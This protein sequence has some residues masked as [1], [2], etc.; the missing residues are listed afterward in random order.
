MI[1]ERRNKMMSRGLVTTFVL[2]AALLAVAGQRAALVGA[3]APLTPVSNLSDKDATSDELREE[4]HQS[5][6]LTANGRVSIENLNGGVRVAVW[7]QNEVKVD[8]VKRAFK[9]E[10]L[11]EAK[12]DVSATADG[13]RIRTRYPDENQNFTDEEPRRN[14][15]PATVEYSLTIPRQAHLESAELVNGSLEIEGLEGDVKASCVNGRVTAR[16]LKGEAKLSTINGGLDATFTHLDE[17]KAISLNSVNGRVLLTIPSDANATLR[18]STVHGGITN[19]F[20]LPVQHGEYVGH[21]LYGQLGSGG[22]RIRLGNVNG[23][24]TI[25]HAADGRSLSPATSLQADKNKEKDKAEKELKDEVRR[26]VEAGRREGLSQTEIDGL[27]REVQREVERS[28]RDAQIEVQRAEREIQREVQREVQR[29]LQG[30]MQ[31]Q[32]REAAGLAR[33]QAR[34]ARDRAGR[35][36][37]GSGG[38]FVDHQTKS[39]PVTGTPNVNVGTFDGAIVVH[40]WDKAEVT[41]TATKRAGREESLKRITLQTEQQGSSI[42]IIAKSAEESNGSAALEVYVPRNSKLHVSSNDGRLSVEGVSGD[43]NLRTGNGSIEVT[44]GR[45]QLQANTGDGQIQ[46]QDFDG[47]VDV[48]TGDGSIS[49]AGRFTALAARTGDG[50]IALAVPAA[51]SFILETDADALAPEGLNVSEEASPSKRVKRWKVGGGGAVFT[52]HTGDG[53]VTLRA[54]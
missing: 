46:I 26:G 1:T 18:A 19:D 23:S 30:E 43:L 44:N 12:I 16:G 27:T 40:G 3:V 34:Q 2:V 38:R 42:S 7:D 8:A 29:E 54:R 48:R 6:P 53:R 52:L 21:D 45:G 47:Q 32:T 36:A 49:L 13:V 22:P 51:S 41:Y 31:Q 11:D 39:F 37:S 20:G 50:S 28:L 4:F 35:V 9:R 5:Y 14:N 10:R 24:V 25:K 33:E 17:S 15:N